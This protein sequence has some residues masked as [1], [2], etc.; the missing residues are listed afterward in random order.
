MKLKTLIGVILALFLVTGCSTNDME[1]KNPMYDVVHTNT[2]DETVIE[3]AKGL[4]KNLEIRKV[5]TGDIAMTSFVQLNN[6]SKTSKFGRILSESLFHELYSRHVKLL[7]FRAKKA[8]SVDAQGE[9]YL[10]RE[11]DAL[12][13]SINSKHILVGTY[14]KTMD[15]SLMINA[16]IIN[17]VTG[18]V[19]STS[20][21]ILHKYDCRFFDTCRP[22][23]RAIRITGTSIKKR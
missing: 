17:T 10:S 5:E 2:L 19:I 6:F 20:S 11:V 22:A 13:N 12:N 3:L 9:Y 1:M 15:K 18:S 21:V 4:S 14:S 23:N 16:R 8:I 7:D